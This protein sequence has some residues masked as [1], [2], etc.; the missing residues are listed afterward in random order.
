M[1]VSHLYEIR[2]QPLAQFL[3]LEWNRPGAVRAM[4]R[5][6][7]SG[8]EYLKEILTEYMKKD[9]TKYRKMGTHSVKVSQVVAL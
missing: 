4:R 1:L 6:G 5:D 3:V 8:S 7:A 9:F 2:R